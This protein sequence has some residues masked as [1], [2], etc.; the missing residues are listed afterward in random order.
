MKKI[1]FDIKKLKKLDK[2]KCFICKNQ[3]NK[4]NI[5]YENNEIIAFLDLYPPTKG[6]ILVAT[7]KHIEEVTELSE[8]E[9]LNL[10]KILFK[11]S[12]AIKKAFNPKR[13]YILKTGDLVAHLHFH[14]MPIYN[15]N[16]N[17]TDILLK[18]SIIKLS[19][20][21]RKNITSEIKEL[22]E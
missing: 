13:I 22:I 12:K 20:E 9:Y 7:K 3:I 16:N 1:K 17:F 21:E 4:E 2:K 11:I 19:K 18:K 10:Q 5:I 15:I 14:I 6:Y 8:N